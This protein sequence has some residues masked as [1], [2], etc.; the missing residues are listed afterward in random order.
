M[1]GLTNRR[2]DQR[3]NQR[4]NWITYAMD[5]V[6]NGQ[7]NKQAERP[8]DEQSGV[9]TKEKG[10][11]GVKLNENDFINPAL[12]DYKPKCLPNLSFTLMPDLLGVFCR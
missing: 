7:T 1:D 8:T 11:G 3:T 12:E 2:T 5:R 4:T 6:T 9:K 10:G